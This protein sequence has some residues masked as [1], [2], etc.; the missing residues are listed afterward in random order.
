M[1]AKKKVRIAIW[2]MLIILLLL[3]ILSTIA[4]VKDARSGSMQDFFKKTPI[5]R[6]LT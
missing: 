5:P 6:K 1:T 2:S 4:F 3:S